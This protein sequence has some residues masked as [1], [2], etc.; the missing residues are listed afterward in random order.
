MFKVKNK[1]TTVFIVNFEQISHLV[2]VFLSLT[3]TP[4]S[5]VFIVNF[6]HANAG[7]VIEIIQGF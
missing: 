6:E 3:F 2:L 5:S 1:D 4:C 7:W